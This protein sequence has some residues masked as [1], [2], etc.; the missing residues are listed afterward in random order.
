MQTQS[1]DA[2]DY[3]SLASSVLKAAVSGIVVIDARGNILHLNPS[4]ER[5]FGWRSDEVE[6]R[7][8]GV[9]MPSA[10]ARKHDRYMQNYHDTGQPKIL[11]I[12]REVV[13]QRKDG[14]EFP[15]FLSTSECEL[16]GKRGYVGVCA[17]LSGLKAAQEKAQVSEQFFREVVDSQ[18]ELLCRFDEAGRVT[19]ANRAFSGF[20]GSSWSEG[21]CLLDLLPS[22]ER[23]G[24]ARYIASLPDD[25]TPHSHQTCIATVAGETHWQEW[26]SRRLP[27]GEDG[28]REYQSFV[29]DITERREAEREVRFLV[30]HDALTGLSNRH[31]LA[32]FVDRTLQSGGVVTVLFIDLD[33]FKL[34]NDSVGHGEGDLL[35]AEIGRRLARF[36]RPA[37]VLA[38]LGG[39][40]FVL[41]V[42][43]A[44]DEADIRQLGGQI[45]RSVHEPCALGDREYCIEASIGVSRAPGDGINADTLL[46][47]ADLAMYQA[48]RLGGGKL[49]FYSPTLHSDALT[50][51]TIRQELRNA[52]VHDELVLFYQ[53][54]VNLDTGALV[55]LEALVRWNHPRRGLLP[56]GI[57]LPVA[58]QYGLMGALS[59]WVF[60]QACRQRA[61]FKLTGLPDVPLSVNIDPVK[62][63]DPGFIGFVQGCLHRHGIR[64][65][66][67]GVEVTENVAVGKPDDVI[68]VFRT[69]H[70]E[71]LVLSLDD[72][73][74]GYSSLGYLRSFPVETIKLDRAFVRDIDHDEESFELVRAV[75]QMAA[76]LKRTI[77]TEG[78]ETAAHVERVRQ[79]GCVLC[80]GFYFS[81]PLPVDDLLQRYVPLEAR[82]VPAH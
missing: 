36:K 45:I 66:E 27:P 80:Q 74:T 31:A 65:G 26:T 78:V 32:R 46:R 61:A 18:T 49:E 54:Q 30:N 8:I 47:S 25:G 52:I 10:E 60:E 35:L 42:T 73:G 20:F 11:G 79:A 13:A 15:I 28:R 7:N 37:D 44:M 12:G 56:P 51:L 81:K 19:F 82:L 4:S 64:P 2:D 68:G 34:V 6:G 22:Y 41:A 72:F 23:D 38:R 3:A 14:T 29:L 59:E 67:M 70:D 58:E 40:E 48:K 33:N 50:T 63:N 21:A 5:M 16:G 39:D 1:L 9:L 69:L 17:D 55:G 71:G 24:M 76:A 57:F 43:G 53:P 62:F 77:L 75:V